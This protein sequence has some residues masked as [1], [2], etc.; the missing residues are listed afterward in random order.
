MRAEIYRAESPDDVV[1]VATWRGRSA[2][3]DVRDTTIEGLD[4]LVRSAPA[5]VDDPAL[6]QQGTRGPSV[7]EPGD[8]EWF[9]AAVRT[10]AEDLGL[11]V[12]FIPATGAGG[13]DPASQYR[14][15]AQQV[16]HLASER[17]G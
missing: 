6:R 13:W 15:F 7:L 1:A 12:R 9:L 4:G 14:T 16:R 5:V 17:G 10:R 3:I 11:R 2:A 8:L